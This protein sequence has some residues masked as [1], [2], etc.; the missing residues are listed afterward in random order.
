MLTLNQS[1]NCIFYC[2][3]SDFSKIIF[4]VNPWLISDVR[5]IQYPRSSSFTYTYDELYSISSDE[6]F[7][8]SVDSLAD[9]WQK[10]Q[11]ILMDGNRKIK[12]HGCLICFKD[13]MTLN[14][15]IGRKMFNCAHIKVKTR[16]KNKTRR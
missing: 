3:F 15:E 16:R 9:Q 8:S 10:I 2:C 6:N 13:L 12:I 4:L 1:V 7:N 11:W 5:T 14:M